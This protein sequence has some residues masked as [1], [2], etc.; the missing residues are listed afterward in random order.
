[1]VMTIRDD[2]AGARPRIGII[3][4]D[5]H[6][7]LQLMPIATLEEGGTE[8]NLGA[9]GPGVVIMPTT[10]DP[11]EVLALADG[12]ILIGNNSGAPDVV[13]ANNTT[14]RKFLMQREFIAENPGTLWD[15]IEAADIK[16]GV[17]AVER[18]GTGADNS[19]TGPGA[20]I[21]GSVG[22]AFTV[23]LAPENSDLV[24]KE[25]AGTIVFGQVFPNAYADNSINMPKLV[26]GNPRSVIGNSANSVQNCDFIQATASGQV[27]RQS[28][29]TIGF[30]SIGTAVATTVGAAG[31]ASALPATPLGYLTIIL[32][33][34][35]SV[36][37]PYY[38]L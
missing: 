37:I 28:G 14:E 16:S 12:E 7:S 34:G 11:M 9:A 25:L 29:T 20:L 32:P 38:N 35:T 8:S 4:D 26:A 5:D 3:R 1:M 24:L 15:V 13:A 2:D 17:L 36:K 18:G 22:S 10:G 30:G 31:G 23:E 19:A 33:A 27:L 6:R 21:Q